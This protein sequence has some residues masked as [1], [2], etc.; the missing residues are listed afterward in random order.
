MVDKDRPTLKEVKEQFK[1]AGLTSID[2]KHLNYD[3]LLSLAGV[4]SG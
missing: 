4:K 3:Q 2:Y 1:R